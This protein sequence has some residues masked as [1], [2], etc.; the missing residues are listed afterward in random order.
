MRAILFLLFCTGLASAQIRGGNDPTLA[1]DPDKDGAS[2]WLE[3]WTGGNERSG[4]QSEAQGGSC[5]VVDIGTAK[6]YVHLQRLREI[7]TWPTVPFFRP[8]DALGKSGI[9]GGKMP[10][11]QLEWSADLETWEQNIFEPTALVSAVDHD[12]G[13]FTYAA[14]SIYP[15]WV[16]EG[17]ADLTWTAFRDVEMIHINGTDLALG[18]Y[19]YDLTTDSVDFVADMLSAGYVADVDLGGTY[20]VITVEEVNFDAGDPLDA[21]MILVGLDYF[22]GPFTGP[23]SVDNFHRAAGY[24]IFTTDDV[25]VRSKQFSRLSLTR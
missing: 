8:I 20:P 11:P 16:E 21:Y 7:D 25:P 9:S 22:D 3:Y 4:V 14:V 6:Y 10:F 2:N 1:P 15:I 12:D 19:P 5:V 17:H 24:V 23:Y 13:T 18:S